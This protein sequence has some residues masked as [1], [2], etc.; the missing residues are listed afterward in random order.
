MHC[1]NSQS[2]RHI[3][4]S[5]YQD[6]LDQ[7]AAYRTTE[8]YQKARRKRLGWVEPLFGEAKQWH[9]LVEPKAPSGR[10]APLAL[11]FLVRSVATCHPYHWALACKG[12]FQHA[13]ELYDM[14]GDR[15]ILRCA[16]VHRQIAPATWLKQADD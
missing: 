15:L 3:F 1:T 12:L 13:A 16:G 7:A 2:G 14:R 10:S 4:R 6:Y 5:F 11:Y 8:A 9:D